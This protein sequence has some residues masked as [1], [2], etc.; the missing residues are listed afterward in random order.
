MSNAALARLVRLERSLYICFLLGVLVPLGDFV[1][2]L[3]PFQMSSLGWRYGA[4]GVLSS[5]T[6][7]PL[8]AL[9]GIAA[10][11]AV[12]DNRR[13]LRTAA[14]VSLAAG[15]LLVVLSLSFVLDAV[16]LRRQA[17]ADAVGT[18]DLGVV[19]ALA[20]HLVTIVALAWLGL[21]GLGASQKT[22]GPAKVK[23][24]SPLVMN[25]AKP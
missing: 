23:D 15:S 21:S 22:D 13:I 25:S 16:Q 7:M 9:A 14:V 1:G 8:L 10:V 24:G 19:K 5:F 4:E 12:A 6:L 11:A 20:K 2:N 17:P 3:Y 18:F